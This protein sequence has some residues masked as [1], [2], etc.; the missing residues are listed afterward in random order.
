MCYDVEYYSSENFKR[1]LEDMHN[2][3][4]LGKGQQNYCC[5]RPPLLN[6]KLDHV[7]IDELH[8]LLRVMDVLLDNLVQDALNWDQKGNWQRKK[9]NHTATHL[10]NLIV[11]IKSC[12]ISFSVWEKRN[13]NGKCRTKMEPGVVETGQTTGE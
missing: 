9:S 11:T 8:L 13:A 1:T 2:C 12:G 4:K 5:V 6:I 10:E 3:A 7:V